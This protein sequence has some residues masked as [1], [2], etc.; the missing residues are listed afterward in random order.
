MAASAGLLP[1]ASGNL[2]LHSY[3]PGDSGSPSQPSPHGPFLQEEYEE[4]LEEILEQEEYEDPGVPVPQ[5]EEPE[6]KPIS[7]SL[8]WVS[9]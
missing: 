8:C 3:L 6:G 7:F 5:V 9:C 1:G 2:A 4:G